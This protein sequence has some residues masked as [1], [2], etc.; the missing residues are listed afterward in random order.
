MP[1]VRAT[2]GTA[3]FQ[4]SFSQPEDVVDVLDA[5]GSEL[6]D[7]SRLPC[8]ALDGGERCGVESDPDA[9]VPMCE[10]HLHEVFKYVMRQADDLIRLPLPPVVEPD[11]PRDSVVY[12]ARI[13][14]SVKIGWSCSLKSRM[15]QINP[16]ELMVTEP[17]GRALEQRRHVEFQELWTHGEWFRL[18]PE[19]VSH[20]ET[21][22]SR[23]ADRG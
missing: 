18:G 8:V 21:L 23:V 4:S 16:E 19:L 12:Y 5:G 2:R 13:G 11:L 3:I 22:K 9:P 1:H 14:S 20:I 17:G 6:C 10:Y 15:K 7:P